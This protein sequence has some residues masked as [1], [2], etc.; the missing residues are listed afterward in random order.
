MYMERW[1]TVNEF[2]NNVRI[3]EVRTG[4][5]FW[6]GVIFTMVHL[7]Y[8]G[9]QLEYTAMGVHRRNSKCTGCAQDTNLPR[10]WVSLECAF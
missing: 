5:F 9:N 7:I 2:K 3:P 4:L 6:G 1:G 8:G 10:V